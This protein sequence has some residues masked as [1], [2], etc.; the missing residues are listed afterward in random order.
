MTDLHRY[1]DRGI[2]AGSTNNPNR[3]KGE[4]AREGYRGKMYYARTKNMKTAETKLL[5]QHNF[6]HN[7]QVTSNQ[8]PEEG[9]I[10]VIQGRKT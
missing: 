1:A 5:S 10:Y 4:Y 3:R 2:R 8:Q 7:Q 6:K 9:Y